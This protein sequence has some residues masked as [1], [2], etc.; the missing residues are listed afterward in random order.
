MCEGLSQLGH[1]VTLFFFRK[2]PSK[3]NFRREI[4]DAYG[5]SLADVHLV[6]VHSLITKGYSMQI[7]LCAFLSILKRLV[8]SRLPDVVISR[9]LYGTYLMRPFLGQRLLF[10]THRPEFGIRKA[11]QKAVLKDATIKKVVISDALRSLLREHHQHSIQ[12]ICAL[13][14]AAPEGIWL[15]GDHEK[16][17]LKR[18]HLNPQ[19]REFDSIA[20][21]FGQLRPGR[22]IEIIEQM[23][24]RIPNTASAVWGGTPEQIRKFQREKKNRNLFFQGRLSHSQALQFMQLTDVLLMPYQ[25]G[26]STGARGIYNDVS[27]WMSPMKL[28]EYMASGVPIISSRLP[29]LMEIL[30]HEENALL[31]KPDDPN[32]W[33]DSLKRLATPSE[34]SRR[35]AR[36]AYEAYRTQYNWKTRGQQMIELF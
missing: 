28:F 13:P 30:K 31:A 21:Y 11:I 8:S 19:L 27:R 15:L 24:E 26:I 32:E 5:S 4:K 25:E 35:I 6:P 9:N 29:V 20:G 36:R 2:I 22:G 7:A 34:F 1:R 33:C 16:K 3:E 23:S 17:E 10:E 14:D 12:S 18:T